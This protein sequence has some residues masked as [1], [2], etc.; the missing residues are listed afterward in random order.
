MIIILNA[1]KLKAINPFAAGTQAGL[2]VCAPSRDGDLVI[3]ELEKYL[4]KW[5]GAGKT[6][7]RA[8]REINMITTPLG[9]EAGRGV[10]EMGSPAT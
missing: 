5:L 7:Q 10:G 6:A 2:F 1:E 8:K 3:V 4:T 9:E